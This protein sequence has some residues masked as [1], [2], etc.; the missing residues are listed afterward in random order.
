MGDL[1]LSV[2]KQV[3]LLTGNST[4]RQEVTNIEG[5]NKHELRDMIQTLSQELGLSLEA[6]VD[7]SKKLN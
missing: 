1:A 3:Q 4:E 7:N 2:S 5:L 6:G